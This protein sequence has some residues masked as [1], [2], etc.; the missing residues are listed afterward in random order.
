MKRSIFYAIGLSL[1]VVACSQKEEEPDIPTNVREAFEKSKGKGLSE[2]EWSIEDE[3][4]VV[5]YMFNNKEKELVYN[6]EGVIVEKSTEVGMGNIPASIKEYIAQNYPHAEF[7]EAEQT[8]NEE[9][10]FYEV[11]LEHNGEEIELYFNG[12]GKLLEVEIEK[13]E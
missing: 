10:E 4:Y 1:A 6:S 5:E 13:E 12:Q 8:I 9:G 2:I 3:M 11:E 7:S